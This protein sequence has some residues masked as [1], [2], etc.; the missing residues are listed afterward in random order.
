MHP[1]V[2]LGLNAQSLFGNL[3]K[4]YLRKRKEVKDA[5]K[6]GTSTGVVARAEKVSHPYLFLSWLDEYVQMREGRNNLPVPTRLIN[7]KNDAEEDVF[8]DD[9][10]TVADDV[11]T[12]SEVNEALDQC[13]VMTETCESVTAKP[14]AG[15]AQQSDL[16]ACHS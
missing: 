11:T 4:K 3:K 6:S 8:N 15:W 1:F 10:S 12:S 9:G 5:N 14:S 13:E 7:P 16:D 2:F